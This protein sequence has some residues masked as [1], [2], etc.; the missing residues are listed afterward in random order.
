MSFLIDCFSPA[1]M[2]HMVSIANR[3]Q[4]LT[5]DQ[6]RFLIGL[7]MAEVNPDG[8]Y[9][10]TP[11]KLGKF[12]RIFG[13][14]LNELEVGQRCEKDDCPTCDR[15]Q[16]L[17]DDFHGP[18]ESREFRCFIEWFQKST[19]VYTSSEP[20]A[21]T[22][23]ANRP[24]SSPFAHGKPPLSPAPAKAPA[25]AA[26]SHASGLPPTAF[27]GPFE[28]AA[29]LRPPVAAPAPAPDPVPAPARSPGP[30]QP[31]APTLAA[32]NDEAA[33]TAA[34]LSPTT[35]APA[36]IGAGGCEPLFI[37]N[38]EHPLVRRLQELSAADPG[39]MDDATIRRHASQL[40]ADC[41]AL[42]RGLGL[43]VDHSSKPQA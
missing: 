42:L 35:P 36:A 40:Q 28:D 27:K 4:L 16:E 23:S 17:L 13:Q 6:K 3:H 41:R 29:P 5:T 43:A 20:V 26:V 18:Q 8:T 9:K 22:Q 24:L 38:H 39:L 34:P 25:P 1:E 2:L 32:V 10:I 30:I 21:P 19:L 12:S 15:L 11:E 31:A 33:P 7:R 37:P 14:F